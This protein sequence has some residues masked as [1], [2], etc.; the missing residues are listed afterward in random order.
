MVV[1]PWSQNNCNKRSQGG[2]CVYEMH[3]RNFQIPTEPRH[4]FTHHFEEMTEALGYMNRNKLLR[5][6]RRAL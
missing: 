4:I 1:T 2:L 5:H 3:M 6:V